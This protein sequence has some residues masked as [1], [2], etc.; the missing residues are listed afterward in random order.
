MADPTGHTEISGTR[1]RAGGAGG[2]A[3]AGRIDAGG[4]AWSPGASGTAWAAEAIRAGGAVGR[5]GSFGVVGIDGAAGIGAAAGRI[6]GAGVSGTAGRLGSTRTAGTGGIPGTDGT[7][8][9]ASAESTEPA[10]PSGTARGPLLSLAVDLV[11]PLLVYYVTRALGAGQ[12]SALLLSGAPPALRLL[13]GAAR[14]RRVDGVDLFFTVLLAAAAL[15][16]L[17]GG[18]PRVLLFKNAALS[19]AVGGWALG[20]AFTGRPLAFQVGQRLHPGGTARAR[21]RIWQDSAPFRRALRVLTALWGAEQLLDGALGSA[22]AA[23]LPTDTVP[24]LDRALSLLLLGL[25]AG[26]TAV[27]TRRFRIRHTLPLFGTPAPATVHRGSPSPAS[28]RPS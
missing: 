25:T 7:D 17:I 26:A 23:T 3:G 9:S 27:Y 8:G 2:G 13:A 12:A 18:G 4:T 10:G 5:A 22:A 24:L 20:T 11:L 16:S 1:G 6:G 15:V 19:L 28:P 14:H 21:D